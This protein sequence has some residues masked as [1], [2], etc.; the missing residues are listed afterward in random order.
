MKTLQAKNSHSSSA[1]AFL[2]LIIC[3]V[4]R[5]PVAANDNFRL[6]MGYM[7]SV[8]Q[9]MTNSEIK[10]AVSLLANKITWKNFDQGKAFY[11]DTLVDMAKEIK[12]GKVQ[13]ACLP[14]EQ[15]MDMR[16]H[17]QL[18]PLLVTATS[19]GT[20]SELLL[21]VRKDSGIRSL[22]GLKSKTIILS[23]QKN[24]SN[25]FSRIWLETLLL[26]L[27]HH[28]IDKYFSF[29]KVTS[30]T[31]QVVLPVFF[32][33]AD[34]CVVTRQFF[35]LTAE[36]NP[37]VAREL[38]AIAHIGNLAQGIISVDTKVPRE[39]RQKM[40]EAFMALNKSPDGR[41]LLMLFQV[42]SFMPFR[43]GYL[44]ATEAL[45]AEHQRLKKKIVRR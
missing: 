13:V 12:D 4:C 41:Q 28:D 8:Y 44:K 26:Q 35:D 16:K 37:Q 39:A 33:Q 6:N 36:L 25:S 30:T 23:Q 2:A 9:E 19:I 21:L 40:K 11:Y 3:L 17:V 27:G 10:A 32:R 34:A 42:T 31:S 38:T 1:K 22:K 14:P 5:T 15:F 45:Y 29:V 43:P 24:V 7:G 18:D 20:E